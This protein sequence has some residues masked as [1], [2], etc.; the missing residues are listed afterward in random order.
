MLSAKNIDPLKLMTQKKYPL[1]R[2]PPYKVVQ[3]NNKSAKKSKSTK[4][5]QIY[6]KKTAKKD[7]NQK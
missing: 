2:V 6:N 4:I 5:K 7:I 1:I 3:N